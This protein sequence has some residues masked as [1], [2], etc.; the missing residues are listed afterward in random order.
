M[1][2]ERTGPMDHLNQSCNNHSDRKPKREGVLLPPH[3]LYHRAARCFHRHA[4]AHLLTIA[5]HGG[6]ARSVPFRRDKH[7]NTCQT[8]GACREK[9]NRMPA[10]L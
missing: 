6:R 4:E 2:R 3:S 7:Q 8:S 5:M 10:H 1:E 9:T